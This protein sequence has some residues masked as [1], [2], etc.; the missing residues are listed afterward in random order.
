MQNQNQKSLPSDVIVLDSFQRGDIT[1]EQ[2]HELQ[3][4]KIATHKMAIE[5]VDEFRSLPFY[6]V[7]D[8]IDV[9]YDTPCV[10]FSVKFGLPQLILAVDFSDNHCLF[11]PFQETDR[12][13]ASVYIQM[14]ARNVIDCMKK[15]QKEAA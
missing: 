1:L 2:A 15:N 8:Y 4:S 14:H 5:F 6:A 7:K 11:D 3:L 10:S 9:E 12:I 13:V